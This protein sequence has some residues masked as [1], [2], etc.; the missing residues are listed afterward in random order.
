L[1]AALPAEWDGDLLMSLWDTCGAVPGFATLIEQADWR[2]LSPSGRTYL[3]RFFT[4]LRWHQDRHALDPRRWRA[5]EPFL[6]RI[7]EL[8]RTVPTPHTDQAMDDLVELAAPRRAP[9]AYRD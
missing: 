6:P 5:I 8:A 2:T 3:L 1:L 7:E 9:K 4:D